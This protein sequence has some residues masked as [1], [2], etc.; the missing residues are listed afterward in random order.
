MIDDEMVFFYYINSIFP[1]RDFDNTIFLPVYSYCQYILYLLITIGREE[2]MVKMRKY[3][4]LL[5]TALILVV[6]SACGDDDETS[7]EAD[8]DAEETEQVDEEEADDEEA[9]DEEADDE[10]DLDE[11][12]DTEES[13]DEEAVDE[14][15]GGGLFGEAEDEEE[16]EFGDG[17]NEITLVSDQDGILMEITYKADGDMVTEQ[18]AHNEMSY[19]A[20]GVSSKEEAK[21]LD[22]LKETEET[23]N[24]IDDVE[25][26][27]DFR[28]DE[29]IEDIEI[30]FIEA[31]MEAVSNLI[32]SEFEGDVEQ[33]V[34]LSQSVDMLIDSGFTVKEE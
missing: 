2:R 10:E 28:D 26:E 29:V 19:E 7:S 13:D 22:L 17:E 27:L 12:E 18:L 16:I 9:D 8:E 11:E 1:S 23:Y 30:D 32:G 14:S 5:F 4:L 31:D 6:M 24:E 34:S 3:L 33:G 15:E 21:E 20:L 25:Y